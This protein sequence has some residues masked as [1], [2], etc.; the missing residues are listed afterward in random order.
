MNRVF[1]PPTVSEQVTSIASEVSSAGG[2][3]SMLSW[4]G[5]LATLFGIGAFVLT[6]G[7]MGMRAI[8]IGIGLVI[9]NFV[10]ANYL[11]WFIIP[12]LVVQES[13]QRCGVIRLSE[14]I[15]NIGSGHG[16]SKYGFV[17]RYNVVYFI[18]WLL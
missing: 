15:W 8:L 6:R 13:S 14:S 3:L 17:L 9:L 2:E 5:G 7:T 10:I 11:T 12:V 18:S 1:S 16:I 4:I